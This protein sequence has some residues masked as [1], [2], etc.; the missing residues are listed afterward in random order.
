MALQMHNPSSGGEDPGNHL[1]L[2]GVPWGLHG[3]VPRLNCFCAVPYR[4][5]MDF[6]I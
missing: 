1:S 2:Q 4:T 3:G 6:I 5:F